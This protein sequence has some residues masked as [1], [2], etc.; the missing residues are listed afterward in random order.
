MVF[1]SVVMNFW[2]PGQSANSA[3][4]K[5]VSE[6][7]Q[8]PALPLFTL[9]RCDVVNEAL[10][11]FELHTTFKASELSGPPVKISWPSSPYV[12][13]DLIIPS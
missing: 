12:F 4:A 13:L 7:R 2:P 6:T 10:K 1:L 11:V 5:K 8:G 9:N 3:K